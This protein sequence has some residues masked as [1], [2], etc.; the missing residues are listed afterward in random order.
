MNLQS[1]YLSA[2]RGGSNPRTLWGDL[3]LQLKEKMKGNLATYN[4]PIS[5]EFIDSIDHLRNEVIRLAEVLSTLNNR[6]T[7]NTSR[8]RWYR[9]CS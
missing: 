1:D 6:K 2:D 3:L 9:S 8:Y 4:V 7:T 5:I